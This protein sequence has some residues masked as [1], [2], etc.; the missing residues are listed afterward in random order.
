MQKY[1]L[2]ELRE[3]YLSFFESKDHVR[4][5]SFSLVP[6]NDPSVLLIN[7]G[8]TPLKP[9]F[10]GR[11][12]P[13]GKRVTTCQKCIRTPDIENVGKTS[14]HGTFFEMLGNFSFGDYFKKEAIPWAWE[15]LTR[16]L[17][18]PEDRLYVS[19]YEEDD[20]AYDI[21]NMDVG[22]SPDKIFRMGKE[23]NFWEHGTG[24]C[25]PCSEI[26]FD[27]GPDKGCGK[28]DCA[29][30]CDCDRYIEVWNNVF[31][32]FDKQED[33]T[34]IELASKNIDTGLGLERLACIMQGVDNIF[35]VDAIRAILNRICSVS[36]VS[37]GK[38]YK[39]DV[40]IRV[41]TDHT[42]SITMMT[43]DGILPSNEG[44]GYVLRRLLR[45][46]ARHGRLLGI[47]RMFLSEIVDTVI[48]CFGE[49]Y[50]NLV[51]KQEYINKVIS[52]EEERFYATI[53][54]G[55]IILE[56]YI[57]QIKSSGSGKLTGE[58]V[59]KLHDTFGF[60]VDMTREIAAENNV[61]IDEEGFRNE[62]KIQ[63]NKSREA[64]KNK[65]G[66]AWEKDL[67]ANTDK[68]ATTQF[69][70]YTDYTGEAVVQ[71]IVLNDELADS[72]QQDDEV[73]IVLNTTPFYAESGGQTGDSGTI[74]NSN[75]RMEVRDCRKTTDGKFLHIGKVV[76]GG[77]QVGDKV[78]ASIDI[79]KRKA[80]ARNHT[81][82]HLLHRALKNVL[83][84][85]VNQAGSFVNPERLRF[86]FTHFSAMSQ[87]QLEAVENE[88]NEKI[89]ANLAVNTNE[90]T[91]DEARKSGATALFDEKY[92]E[93]VRVV[94]AGDYSKELC[95]GT[96][97]NST[98]EAGLIKILS[99]NGISAGV[100]R[101]E[102]L[103]G[104]NAINYYKE[105]EGILKHASETAKTSVDD[106]VKKIENL[107]D[108]IKTY[109]KELEEVSSKM[110]TSSLDSIIGNAKAVNAIKI[111]AAK[112]KGLDMNALR[113]ASDTLKNKIGSGVVILVSDKD[114][115]VNLIV[116]ATKDAVDAGIHCGNIIKEAA[117]ACGGGG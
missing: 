75:F 70:G 50:P 42:R 47:N 95:G 57:K 108:D 62:M 102:A 106:L 45:R 101:I 71:F 26:Y 46:A 38:E 40:S 81:A 58:M 59:F 53:D 64:H 41:I 109:K 112:L 33:G 73:T 35:E 1:G 90:M 30:G 67:F 10:T 27:R 34:Y 117:A 3:M 107:F 44:R 63:K 21:W 14:R 94:S 91:V 16:V 100:R 29:V 115:K 84:D 116:S 4:L 37:Y 110:V 12:I 105:K 79:E 82:T 77:V 86:D 72:A 51:E 36:G 19:V 17:E 65:E 103:T 114:N 99:E 28:P 11:E 2:N 5:P 113:N 23:D 87:D 98:S 80:T 32:Q 69:I 89:L 76:Y 52:L 20:E 25:G 48:E 111:V 93:K 54:Q 43:S 13:P 88:V 49:A 60:P 8:M 78:T 7:A 74:Y 68:T 22:L 55:M 85:H 92:C 96:H 66:S 39:K 9:Y 18:I 97:I 104:F 31:T 24:P 56:D 61:S 6:Q 83:G 15:F